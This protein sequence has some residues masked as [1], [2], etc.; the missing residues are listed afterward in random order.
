MAGLR[1]GEVAEQAGVPST[2]VR[3]Y[4]RIALVTPTARSDGGYRLYTSGP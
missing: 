2:T 3:Y 1:I 4:E